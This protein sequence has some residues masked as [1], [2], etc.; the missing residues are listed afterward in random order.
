MPW[1]NAQE[2]AWIYREQLAGIRGRLLR[3]R[4]LEAIRAADPAAYEILRRRLTRS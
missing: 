2:R 3:D 1:P 4:F